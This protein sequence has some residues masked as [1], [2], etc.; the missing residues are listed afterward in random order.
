MNVTELAIYKKMFGGGTGGSPTPV[1]GTAIPQGT[2]PT[3]VYFNLNNSPEQTNAYL[4]QLTYVQTD[5]FELPIYGICGYLIG[6]KTIL[7]FAVQA[8][9]EESKQAN[10]RICLFD[11]LSVVD[12]YSAGDIYGAMMSEYYENNGFK[13]MDHD[14]FCIF[15]RGIIFLPTEIISAEELTDFMGFP[16]G[17]ENEKIKNVLSITPFTGTTPSNKPTAYTVP[18]VD[19]LP[20]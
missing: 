20:E 5:L 12:I 16:L 4:S 18:S 3:Y 14:P 11:G 17:L 9:Y 13:I 19:E 1:E 15:S 10:Y 8:K 7:M 2:A 6:E